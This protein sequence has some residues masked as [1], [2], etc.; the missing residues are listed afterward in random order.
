MAPTRFRFQ[1][2]YTENL[3]GRPY[4]A[5]KSEVAPDPR[6][7]LKQAAKHLGGKG[8]IS[9]DGMD[10]EPMAVEIDGEWISLRALQGAELAVAMATL[11]RQSGCET[12]AQ[13]ITFLTALAED[14]E[15]YGKR[16]LAEWRGDVPTAGD[17]LEQVR[18]G[19]ITDAQHDT[20]A[21]L[22][23]ALRNDVGRAA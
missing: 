3:D 18:D 19:V 4:P 20:A 5:I 21:D 22:A 17:L 1:I 13:V 6:A 2:D 12:A 10:A 9:L 15:A 23:A 8:F 7:A 16:L 11:A 14:A